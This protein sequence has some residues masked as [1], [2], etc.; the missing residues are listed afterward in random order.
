MKSTIRRRSALPFKEDVMKKNTEKS[1]K[2]LTL[3]RETLACLKLATGG[4]DKATL[5]DASAG[6][7]R[8]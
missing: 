1:V 6:H 3:N 5:A 8:C 7:G 4:V 2:K